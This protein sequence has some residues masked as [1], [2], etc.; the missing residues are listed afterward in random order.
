MP[1]AYDLPPGNQAASEFPDWVQ[2]RLGIPDG[3]SP[4]VCYPLYRWRPN[5]H[6]NGPRVESTC[7]RCLQTVVLSAHNRIEYKLCLDCIE[8]ALGFKLEED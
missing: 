7:T 8:W 5:P 1:D 6:Y 2:E 4:T 3:V